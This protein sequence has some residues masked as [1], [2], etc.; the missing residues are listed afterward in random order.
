M[1]WPTTLAR[2]SSR[3]DLSREESRL[4]M[5]TVM[6]GEATPAQIAAL[7][8][9][10]RMKGETTDEMTGMTEAIRAAAVPIDGDL[11]R[12]RIVDLVGT[13]GD[14]AGTFNISTTAALV[15][16]GAGARIAKH[17]NRSVSSRC[18]SADVLEGLG[19]VI[20]LQMGANLAL[21][22]ETS[23]AFF[24]APLYHPSFRHAGP[25]RRELGIR[26]IFNFL[27]PL[28][29]PAGARRQAVGVSDP[30]MAERMIGVLERLGSIYSFVFCGEGGI[31]E[32]VPTGPTV[33]HRLKDGELTQAEFTPEDF[34]VARVSI[35]Q[36]A[37]GDVTE[38]VAILR[39]VLEGEKGPRRDAVLVNAAPALVAADLASGFVEAVELARRSI[40]SGAAEAVLNKTV[41]R[42]QE[43][44]RA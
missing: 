32:I 25:V 40:D 17:G 34:G 43:L 44:A 29:N 8:V 7:I 14:R 2:L 16:A 35:D 23:F 42:S 28:A 30:I 12:D 26:T 27:G 10:W 19:V 6:N 5:E 38:N 41:E 22:D 31:D 4:A 37:G 3:M 20:D 11:D 21:L 13:G 36:L 24:Y 9:A 39:S 18:G 1:D 15:A 33:I